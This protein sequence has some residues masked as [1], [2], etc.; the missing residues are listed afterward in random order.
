MLA[1]PVK[2]NGYVDKHTHSVSACAFVCVY[3]CA[4]VICLS[5]P[6]YECFFFSIFR[7]YLSYQY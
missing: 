6:V 7:P 1:E 2:R 4:L 3:V 5:E